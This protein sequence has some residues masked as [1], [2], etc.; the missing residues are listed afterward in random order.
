MNGWAKYEA[1]Q[2]PHKE[3]QREA[4]MEG[5]TRASRAHR[6]TGPYV[7][8]DLSWELARYLDTEISSKSTSSTPCSAREW[9]GWTPEER[10]GG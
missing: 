5:P 9:H 8:R 3:T 6:E 2:W 7:V 10:V 4:A 1:D